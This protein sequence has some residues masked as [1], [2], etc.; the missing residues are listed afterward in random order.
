MVVGVS[1]SVITAT[2]FIVLSGTV[3][4]P[5][6]EWGRSTLTQ[7]EPRACDS[8]TVEAKTNTPTEVACKSMRRDMA[9]SLKE[10]VDTVATI[11]KL[12]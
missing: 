7:L 10:W 4:A 2:S 5:K 9:G 8:H 3:V 11:T 6:R 12:L 1:L